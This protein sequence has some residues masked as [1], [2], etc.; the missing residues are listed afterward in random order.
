M[1]R[2]T[3]SQNNKLFSVR[4]SQKARAK[5]PFCPEFAIRKK[6]VRNY[7]CYLGK[8]TLSRTAL[9]SN[10]VYACNIYLRYLL[11]SKRWILATR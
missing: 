11:F 6:L 10:Y 7:F 8:D 2:R 1:Y 5:Y 9:K 4:R 3:F